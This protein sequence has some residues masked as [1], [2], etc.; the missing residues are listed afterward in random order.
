MACC[1]RGRIGAIQ[2][3]NQA[4]QETPSGAPLACRNRVVR[5]QSWCMT[6]LG[7]TVGAGGEAG[8]DGEACHEMTSGVGGRYPSDECGRLVL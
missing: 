1:T 8:P 6:G 2:T 7:A 5:F 4:K 3:R